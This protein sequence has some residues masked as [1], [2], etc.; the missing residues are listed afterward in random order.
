VP[1]LNDLVSESTETFLVNLT[2]PANATI[3]DSVGLGTI[4]DDD[5]PAF[6]SIN[7]VTVLEDAGTATFTVTVDGPMV[8][9]FTTANVSATSNSDYLLTSGTLT[10]TAAGSQTIIVPI[11]DDTLDEQTETFQVVLSDTGGT[12]I[13]RGLGTIVDNDA[14]PMVSIGD[15]SVPEGNAGTTN[16]TFTVTLSAAS[17]QTVTVIVDTVDGTATA[18]VDYVPVTGQVVTFAP[19]VTI[20]TVVVPVIGDLLDEA[21]EVFL[22]NLSAPV[23]ITIAD[24]Q[25]VGT[26][27]DDDEPPSLSIEDV[28]V[29]EGAGPASFTV[30][31]SA[32]SGLPI[33]VSFAT[34]P[35]SASE[36]GDYI[37]TSGTFTFLPGGPLR[38][39]V[40]V[41][42]VDDALFENPESFLVNLTAPTNATIADGVGVGT[43]VDND[44]APT[45]TVTAVTITEGDVGTSPAAFVVT[46]SAPAGVPVTV[47][48][49]T[50]DGSAIASLDYQSV[51][52]VLTFAP[53][54]TAQ[55]IVVPIIGD[56]LDEPLNETF[57]LTL[58]SPTNGTLATPQ[59]TGTILDDDAPPSISV[60]DASVVEGD[61]GTVLAEFLVT[62]SAPSEQV[63][64]IAFTTSGQSATAGADY[65]ETAGT[66]TFQPGQTS[67]TVLVP[68]AGDLL[69][70]A[71]ETFRLTLSA[72][73]NATLADP[74][75]IG[76]ITDDDA[77]PSLSID[78][79][80]VAEGAGTAS[81]TVT[82]SAPSGLP[83]TVSF[84]TT[85]QSA[86]E[87]GDYTGT[88]GTLT[89]LPGGPLT[90]PSSCRS[91]T[92]RC[93]RTPSRSWS[94]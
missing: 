47:R 68:V 20:Q 75:A 38:Q 21:D 12:E 63:V 57:T 43:I 19:G 72:P 84:A 83:I 17:G 13:R 29:A 80:T 41:P 18:P 64:T 28:T 88:S 93:S 11:V 74:V 77:P 25:G 50:A 5:A 58:S 86:T 87:P 45:I 69:D 35:Q 48:F 81:F 36:P 66:L 52:D 59:V 31:L 60:A 7:N 73:G 10:F 65:T 91:S 27:R 1:I 23:N 89:F 33:T 76:T 8:I 79:V 32:P 82:L 53:G 16:A 67:Q 15:V 49:A 39:S 42:I 71:D 44:P 90:R 40:V 94:T 92:T 70:E 14:P 78:D 55:T 34:A 51:A 37:G 6:P 46:L 24:G 26:I 62:L 3:A 56:L 30:T 54:E 4:L 85:P 2:A 22:V 61:S 9:N